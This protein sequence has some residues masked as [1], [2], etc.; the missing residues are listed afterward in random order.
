MGPPVFL[1]EPNATLPGIMAFW[2]LIYI[3]LLAEI[4]L[5]WR[6]RLP[7]AASPRDR[8]SKWL[9]IGSVWAGVLLGFGLAFAI[10]PAA[11]RAARGPL[12]LLGLMLMVLGMA[13]RWYS[14]RVLGRAFTYVVATQ[15]DQMVIEAGPYRWIRHPSYTG[16]LLTILGILLCCTNPLSLLGLVPP[17]IG[18]GY[19][20]HIEEE[21]LLQNLGDSYRAYMRRTR[22]LIPFLT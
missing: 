12:F 10:Q 9:L 16:G 21:A 7:A 19:R 3:W 8:G 6:H 1:G 2:A 5:G 20:I 15:P 18:Y 13:L 17:L 22:R 4:W 11:F 14:I